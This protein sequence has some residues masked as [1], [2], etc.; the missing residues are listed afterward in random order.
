MQLFLFFLNVLDS[1]KFT[2][3]LKGTKA[4]LEKWVEGNMWG[5]FYVLTEAEVHIYSLWNRKDHPHLEMHRLDEQWACCDTKTAEHSLVSLFFAVLDEKRRNVKGKQIFSARRRRV[6]FCVHKPERVYLYD[7]KGQTLYT[8]RLWLS[9][10]VLSDVKLFLN[11]NNSKQYTFLC[12][13][14]QIISGQLREV[15]YYFVYF[16]SRTNPDGELLWWYSFVQWC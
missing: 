13:I 10:L 16:A 1:R 3:F 15:H 4:T 12:L 2:L 7:H 9:C 5:S 8:C 6:D 11:L 14:I